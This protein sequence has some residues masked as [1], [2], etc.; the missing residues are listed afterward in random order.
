MDTKLL[1]MVAQERSA[2]VLLDRPDIDSFLC[3]KAEGLVDGAL[4]ILPG[5]ERYAT[6]HGLTPDGNAFLAIQRTFHQRVGETPS[7][8]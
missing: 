5:G 1:E 6:V 4:H 3:L 8:H 2:I 7:T